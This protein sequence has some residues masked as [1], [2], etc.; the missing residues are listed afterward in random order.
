MSCHIFG[1]MNSNGRLVLGLVLEWGAEGGGVYTRDLTSRQ[2]E[3]VIS[4][5]TGIQEASRDLVTSDPCSLD[6]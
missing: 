4:L 2:A 5:T 3:G 6:V 1:Y